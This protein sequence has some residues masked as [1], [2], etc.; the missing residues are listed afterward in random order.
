[1]LG[2]VQPSFFLLPLRQGEKLEVS[3]YEE[4]INRKNQDALQIGDWKDNEWPPEWI[5]QF[6]GSAIWAEDGSWG[7]RTPICMLDHI[8]R[9]QAMVEI[10][11]SETAKALN[12][13]ARQQ[14]KYATPLPKLFGFGLFASLG[15]WTTWK[16]QCE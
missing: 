9:L 11:T 13:L 16:V 12:R 14:V 4:R 6:Y 15:G 5:M 7:S 2:T 3:I 10:I 8:F 1:V